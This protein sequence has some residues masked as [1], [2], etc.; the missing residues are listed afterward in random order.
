[1]C[2]FPHWSSTHPTKCHHA[3]MNDVTGISN[4]VKWVVNHLEWYYR[5]LATPDVG[6]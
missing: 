1:M 4:Q 5:I 3:M 6:G 2:H